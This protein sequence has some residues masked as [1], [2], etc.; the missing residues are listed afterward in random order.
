MRNIIIIIALVV[1]A[2]GFS[3][4]DKKKEPE[5]DVVDN[6]QN[7][8]R[9]ERENRI[10]AETELETERRKAED[11]PEPSPGL[12]GIPENG[13]ALG[14][15]LGAAALFIGGIVIGTSAVRH[16]EKRRTMEVPD[17]ARQRHRETGA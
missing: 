5:P 11:E 9:Q 8:L 6:L 16:A 4:C 2:L 1:C 3:G 7:E 14:V 12:F 13:V 10:R 17:H 15:G